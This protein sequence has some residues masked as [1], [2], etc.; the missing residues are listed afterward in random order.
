[1]FLQFYYY[2]LNY[3]VCQ[4]SDLCGTAPF[5]G[6]WLHTVPELF[7]Q[8]FLEQTGSW[9]GEELMFTGL[10]YQTRKL[11]FQ[12]HQ[13]TDAID[14]LDRISSFLWNSL[15]LGDWRTF[16]VSDVS[17]H[18]LRGV[19]FLQ[20]KSKHRLVYHSVTWLKTT[21]RRF[22]TTILKKDFDESLDVLEGLTRQWL[23]FQTLLNLTWFS[24]PH[25]SNLHCYSI[26]GSC[27]WV[28]MTHDQNY[29]GIHIMLIIA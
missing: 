24:I 16:L 17:S 9:W 14:W 11:H 21:L 7:S 10:M 18:L 19:V 13:H 4:S 25:D 5:I 29:S 3:Y 8:P 12:L 23:G 2:F 15:M 26:L 6:V 27:P 28:W 22:G 1:M 20:S